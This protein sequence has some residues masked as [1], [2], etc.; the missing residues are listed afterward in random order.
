MLTFLCTKANSGKDWGAIPDEGMWRG[1]S[2][3]CNIHIPR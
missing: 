3:K 2:N 1:K